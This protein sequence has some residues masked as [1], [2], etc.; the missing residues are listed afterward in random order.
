MRSFAG[1]RLDSK[2][3]AMYF[4]DLLTNCQP[5]SCSGI[6][7]AR[8]K[9]LKYLKNSFLIL[10]GNTN[11]VVADANLP[12]LLVG[13]YRRHLDFRRHSFAVILQSIFEQVFENFNE[14]ILFIVD[15]RKV[16]NRDVCA[17]FRDLDSKGC[18]APRSRLL[19]AGLEP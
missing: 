16:V 4:D 7:A 1:R 13:S 8:M 19:S 9:P 15:R 11:A 17:R 10:G 6:F 14:C 2:M 18:F 12:H 5:D 3:T